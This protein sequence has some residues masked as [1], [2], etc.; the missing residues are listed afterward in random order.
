MQSAVESQ[1]RSRSPCSESSRWWCS[2]GSRCSPPATAATIE[3]SARSEA[4]ASPPAAVDRDTPAPQPPPL[5]A[6]PTSP[7]GPPPP[8]SA[9]ECPP[10]PCAPTPPR[11]WPSVPPT[12]HCRLSWGTLAGIGR[13]ESDHGRLGGAERRRRRRGPAARSS[14]SRWTARR[15]CA[16]SPTPTAAAST[17]TPPTTGPS[18]RC[19]SCPPP[20]PATAP[21]ATA[22]ACATRTSST[23]PPSP[24]P[25]YL[26]ADG[27]DTASGEGWWDGVLT[28]NRSV[29]Y[30]RLVW[31]AADR[32]TTATAP[33]YPEPP[34]IRTPA[35]PGPSR[36]ALGRGPA[37]AGEDRGAG[38]L[39]VLH[40]HVVV[41]QRALHRH[42]LR[43][44]V[45]HERQE[46][47][48]GVEVA[49]AVAAVD[50]VVAAAQ[51]LA[52]RPAPRRRRAG[53]ARPTAIAGSPSSPFAAKSARSNSSAR[54]ER[55][56]L[57]LG[58]PDDRLLLGERR[59]VPD[60]DVHA[61]P[62]GDEVAAA[63]QPR[64]ARRRAAPRRARRARP[65]PRP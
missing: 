15:A 38:V 65:G 4:T 59:A 40:H 46:E 29:D 13:V 9:A 10:A 2:S 34:W 32:Y 62:A 11:S 6:S 51:D 48:A 39:D 14:A 25:R 18:G 22:T 36:L 30:A 43:V 45:A 21:T 49:L 1:A 57:A 53:C 5:A 42:E 47:Q 7:P 12:P 19:S 26:C 28:Y 27:R 55:R 56:A 23:T 58:P 33:P 24:P 41:G 20:G 60:L 50:E 8:Q 31:A 52:R 17:A 61:D 35:G 54:A 16:R 63:R 44:R 3:P 37:R 64:P